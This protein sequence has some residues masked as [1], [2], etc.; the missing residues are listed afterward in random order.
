MES[1]LGLSVFYISTKMAASNVLCGICVKF[2]RI[3]A[4]ALKI[5]L[6]TSF[7]AFD[8]GLPVIPCCLLVDL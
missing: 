8:R 2:Y 3:Q 5:H 6:N 7:S 4:Y 1:Y